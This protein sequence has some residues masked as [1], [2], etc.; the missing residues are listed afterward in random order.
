MVLSP[1]GA[2]AHL[3]NV[4]GSVVWEL[5]DGS[6]APEQIAELISSSLPDAPLERVQVDVRAL[7]ERLLE[8]GLIEDL[9]QCGGPASDR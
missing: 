3:L 6:R 8:A 9:D 5:C 7:L 2:A 4:T 1:D